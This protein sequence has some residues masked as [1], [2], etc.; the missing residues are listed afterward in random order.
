MDEDEDDD[1]GDDDRGFFGVGDDDLKVD[2]A[3]G[4]TWNG[5]GYLVVSVPGVY[6]CACHCLTGHPPLIGQL[7]LINEPKSRHSSQ[8]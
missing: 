1:D 6:T 5:I 2:M 3:L 7:P 8:I 4:C